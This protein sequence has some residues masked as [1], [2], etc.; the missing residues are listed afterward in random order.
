M[1]CV[2]ECGLRYCSVRMYFIS[3]SNIKIV[4]LGVM[5]RLECMCI[6]TDIVFLFREQAV[7]ECLPQICINMYRA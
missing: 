3:K 2:G 6:N 1:E 5:D 4:R 7:L